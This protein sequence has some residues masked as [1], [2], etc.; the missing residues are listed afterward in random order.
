MEESVKVIQVLLESPEGKL[1]FL[2]YLQENQRIDVLANRDGFEVR[3][4]FNENLVSN[5]KIYFH[6]NPL[7]TNA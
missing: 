2:K 3:L 5:K 7:F 1:W 4:Y 6:L